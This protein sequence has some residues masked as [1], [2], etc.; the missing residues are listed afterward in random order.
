M[1]RHSSTNRLDK[2]PSK[3]F[4]GLGCLGLALQPGFQIASATPGEH[5]EA[6]D[7]AQIDEM[8]APSYVGLGIWAK[9]FFFLTNLR[10]DKAAHLQGNNLTWRQQAAGMPERTQLQREAKA[11]ARMPPG[12]DMFDIVIR[13]CV[14]MKECHLVSWQIKQACALS[15]G[16]NRASWHGALSLLGRVDK[17]HPSMDCGYLNKA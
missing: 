2:S 13:E 12:S 1:R 4:V 17:A 5:L 14:V 9:V 8:P 6:I 15:F 7:H 11:I 3:V 10:G 16:Q